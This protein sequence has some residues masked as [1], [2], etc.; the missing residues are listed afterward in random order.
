MSMRK[1]VASGL[2]LV[3]VM[4]ALFACKKEEKKPKVE[5]NA[6]GDKSGVSV[7]TKGGK[8]QIGT[9]GSGGSTAGI[10]TPSG[11]VGA[12]SGDCKAGEACV[13]KGMGACNKKCAGGGCAFECHGMGA[14]NFDCP[15]GKCTVESDAM[16]SVNLDCP[17][18]DCTLTC[19][20]T[21]TC[22]L[23]SCKSGCKV[24]CKGVGTCS[25]ASGC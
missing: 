1:L 22:T 4:G 9:S 2:P 12:T 13:C 5:I 17:G 6:S 25:C 24:A 19:K 11:T 10:Q 16:G 7:E 8:V 14:C 21:G 3:L 18:N 23:A 20:G 15:G